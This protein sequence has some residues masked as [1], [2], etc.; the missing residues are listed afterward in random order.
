MYNGCGLDISVLG[1][2]RNVEARSR[3][4]E[5]ITGSERRVQPSSI[6]SRLIP[7]SSSIRSS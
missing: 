6:F 7:G 4:S 2:H 5:Y 1:V 3:L